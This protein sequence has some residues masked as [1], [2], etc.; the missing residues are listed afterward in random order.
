MDFAEVDAAGAGVETAAGVG[1]TVTGA[2]AVAAAS[3]T[4]A[5]AV[6]AAAEVDAAADEPPKTGNPPSA[7][8]FC[9]SRMQGNENMYAI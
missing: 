1:G 8:F 2:G 3:T 4:G 6:A 5:G 7:S 9:L